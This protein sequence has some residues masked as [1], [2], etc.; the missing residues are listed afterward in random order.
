MML[1]PDGKNISFVLE[2]ITQLPMMNEWVKGLKIDT[3]NNLII[4]W[5]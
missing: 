2:R 3:H 4:A 5:D 1:D